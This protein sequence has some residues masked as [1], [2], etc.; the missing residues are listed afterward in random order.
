MPVSDAQWNQIKDRVLALENKQD[1][2]IRR[3][4][5]LI[6]WL[7]GMA[8]NGILPKTAAKM[9]KQYSDEVESDLGESS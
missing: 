5:R 9:F 8:V 3:F 1:K 2:L 4:N 6:K 7:H